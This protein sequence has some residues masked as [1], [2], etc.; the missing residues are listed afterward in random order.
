[1]AGIALAATLPA[2]YHRVAPARPPIANPAP[3]PG[4]FDPLAV[5]MSFGWLPPGEAAVIGAT[6]MVNGSLSVNQVRNPSRSQSPNAN[7]RWRLS[8]FARDIC[9]FDSGH[10]R[11]SCNGQFSLSGHAPDIDGHRA[12]WESGYWP[13]QALV[14][15]YAPGYWA[16]LTSTAGF[17][18]SDQTLLRIAR[19]AIIGADATQPV[20]F[21]VQLTGV[22]SGWRIGSTFV[23]RISGSW[24][25]Q[26]STVTTGKRVLWAD[27]S[28]PSNGLPQVTTYVGDAAFSA[29]GVSSKGS[30]SQFFGYPIQRRIK[31]NGYQVETFTRT[32]GRHAITPPFSVLCAPHADGLLVSELLSGWHARLS[33]TTLFQHMRLLGPKPSAWTTRP[34]S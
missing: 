12:F 19:S 15:T 34:I 2:H 5:N 20:K 23:T 21:A 30:C 7:S 3:L 28:W 4:Q 13:H 26:V 27:A 16:E 11:L 14:W 6:G 31:I 22:P 29:S 24:L 17:Q 32:F 25:A 9:T 1:M 33:V 8:D 10:R 18:Q